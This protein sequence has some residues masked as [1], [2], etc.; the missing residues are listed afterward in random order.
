ME[1]LRHTGGAV[2]VHFGPADDG[3]RLVVADDG[4]GLAGASTDGLGLLG[5]QERVEQAGG[6][7]DLGASEA[8]GA[9]LLAWL[10]DEG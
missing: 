10:P 6:Y 8:G 5:A 1:D 3:W 4:R 2:E 9:R 7:L